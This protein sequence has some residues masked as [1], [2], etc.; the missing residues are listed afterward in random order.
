LSSTKTSD[1][2]PI[3]EP[4]SSDQLFEN[5]SELFD[6]PEDSN[7]KIKIENK[8]VYVQKSVLKSKSN[9]FKSILTEN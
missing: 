1:S 5:I 7:L 9:Y 3:C 2:T 6:N 4:S 8:Y